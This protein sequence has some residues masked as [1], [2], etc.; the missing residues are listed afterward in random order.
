MKKVGK[1]IFIILGS[2]FSVLLIC[3]LIIQVNS[4]GKL[5][6]LKEESGKVISNSLSEKNWL[7]IGG[8]SQGFFI[9]SEN[10]ENPVILFLHGGPGSP[11]LPLIMATETSERLEKYYTVCYWDQR[12]AGMTYSAETPPESMSVGQFVEDTREMTE[13]LRKRFGKNKIYLMG[14]SWGS[15]LG[16]KT[17]EKYPEYYFA[18]MGIGQVT[19]QLLSEQLAYNYMMNQARETGDEKAL[20]QLSKF[21]PNAP[22]FPTQEYLMNARTL[23]MNK[24]G[25]GI[26]HEPYSMFSLFSDVIMFKGYTLS[27]KVGYAKGSLFSLE[28]AFYHVINDKLSDS[29]TSFRIPVYVVHGLYDYQVSY[30]LARKWLESIDAPDKRLYTFEYSAH[31]PNMEEPEKFVET[32]RVCFNFIQ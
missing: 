5:P 26:T 15:Y 10:L 13:Y 22:G 31:S 28:N 29:S 18:Y 12:G 1:I 3:L 8:I 7:D 2:I 21:D 11:E 20:N 17:I 4:P 14:H 30:T 27:D 19:D 16:V 6:P 9:R 24:Y 25:I 32:V 23:Y